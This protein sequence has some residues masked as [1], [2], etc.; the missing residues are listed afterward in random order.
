MC[1][2][3]ES[4]DACHTFVNDAFSRYPVKHVSVFK[5]GVFIT[6]FRVSPKLLGS[7]RA[8]AE[9]MRTPHASHRFY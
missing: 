1:R 6:C 3:F 5:N 8:L 2:Q 9:R 7:M 4:E